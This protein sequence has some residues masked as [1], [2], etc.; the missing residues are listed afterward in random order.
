MSNNST[1]KNETKQLDDINNILHCIKELLERKKY[2]VIGGNSNYYRNDRPN[3]DAVKIY[4]NMINLI[5]KNTDKEL[6]LYASSSEEAD[7]LNNIAVKT[8]LK[9][10]TCPIGKW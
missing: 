7:W 2:I 10:S 9:A 4:I 3:Y 8:K 1:K 6:V 5:K